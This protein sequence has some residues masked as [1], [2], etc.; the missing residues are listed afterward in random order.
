ML[1]FDTCPYL[2]VLPITPDFSI[3]KGN[4]AT[5]SSGSGPGSTEDRYPILRLQGQR[6]KAGHESFDSVGQVRVLLY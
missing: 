4:L 1:D 2:S 3:I 5:G 6:T